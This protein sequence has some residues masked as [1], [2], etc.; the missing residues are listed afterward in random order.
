MC[1]CTPVPRCEL[2]VLV[3]LRV[4]ISVWIT[5]SMCVYINTHII[6]QIIYNCVCVH[7]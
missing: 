2:H 3:P 1:K 4:R 6:Y 7:A 5:I